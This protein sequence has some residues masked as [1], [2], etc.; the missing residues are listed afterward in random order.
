MRFIYK[1]MWIYVE[2]I[3]FV[4]F[5]IGAWASSTTANVVE[6][7][8]RPLLS[9]I[10]LRMTHGHQLEIAH[11]PRHENRQGRA[12]LAR[13]TCTTKAATTQYSLRPE[14]RET[15]HVVVD[16]MIRDLSGYIDLNHG[17]GS[18]IKTQTTT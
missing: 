9:P 16:D 2:P 18:R 17:R 1:A 8:P 10:S 13:S 14:S 6:R 4:S 7:G 5:W 11:D 12:S 3:V 15:T